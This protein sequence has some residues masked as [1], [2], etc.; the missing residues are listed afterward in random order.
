MDTAE[1]EGCELSASEKVASSPNA[2][3][4]PSQ[5]IAQFGRALQPFLLM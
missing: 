3:G 4:V 1:L 5:M 2:V